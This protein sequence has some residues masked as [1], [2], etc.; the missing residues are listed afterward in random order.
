MIELNDCKFLIVNVYGYCSKEANS[1][2]FGEIENCVSSMGSNL[3]VKLII[4]G[5]FNLV[6][7]GIMERYP[8]KAYN[9]PN[10]LVCL[11]YHLDLN[12]IGRKKNPSTKQFTG[13]NKNFTLQSCIDLWL[14][15]TDLVQ[16]TVYIYN[17]GSLK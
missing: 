8:L 5:D 12:D 13:S 4:G 6:M 3:D 16:V 7:N 2:L 9:T 10:D 1:L 14:I 15:S 17:A 11:G